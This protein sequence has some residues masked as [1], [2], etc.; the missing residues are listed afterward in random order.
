M[1]KLKLIAMLTFAFC[2]LLPYANGASA[3]AHDEGAGQSARF[4]RLTSL[5]GK[6]SN[7]YLTVRNIRNS[8]KAGLDP[9][10]AL[11]LS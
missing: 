2:L 3:S 7:P 5:Q 9:S 8:P 11:L 1:M 10:P 4:K 6:W